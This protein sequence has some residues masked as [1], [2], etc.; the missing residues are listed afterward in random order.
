MSR[1]LWL[2]V[3]GSIR[4]GSSTEQPS[5]QYTGRSRQGKGQNSRKDQ[6]DQGEHPDPKKRIDNGVFLDDRS[7]SIHTMKLVSREGLCIAEI[8]DPVA[9]VRRTIAEDVAATVQAVS[10]H[11]REL[12]CEA[13]LQLLGRIARDGNDARWMR[14]AFADGGSLADLVW[15]QGERFRGGG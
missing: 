2:D 8:V 1:S 5:D 15:Q 10:V 9:G 4:F 14:E 12:D 11:A 7:I 13:P 3:R 6:T